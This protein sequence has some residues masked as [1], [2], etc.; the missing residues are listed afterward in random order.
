MK[1]GS[2]NL[3]FGDSDDDSE[4]EESE[5]PFASSDDTE[6]EPS[7]SK[8]TTNERTTTE[9]TPSD[10]SSSDGRE[11]PYFVRRSNVGDERDKRI[12]VHLRP[13][14]NSQESEFRNELA[15]ELDVGEVAKTDAREF[16]LK[17]AFENPEAVAE[18][19][20]DE[21]YGLTD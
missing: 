13:E 9:S 5:P 14:V 11:F 12:E 19:M 4:D 10:E 6:P 3:D 7:Q 17:F 18:L 20:R 1:K 15:D 21:G 8:T 16:A 2:G